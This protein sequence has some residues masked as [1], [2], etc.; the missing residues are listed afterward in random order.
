MSIPRNLS[1]L[2][3]NVDSNGTLSAAAGG[4][5]ATT[6]TGSG[7][8]VLSNSPTLVTPALGTPSS[9]TLT[10]ATG[11]PLSTGVTGNLPVTNLNS[12][13]SASSTTFWRGDG[14]WAIP[15]GGGGGSPAGSNGWVQF[16]NSGSFGAD[17]GFYWDNTNK[18]LSVNSG[19]SPTDSLQVTG[20][21]AIGTNYIL[22][23]NVSPTFYISTTGN[24][25]TGTGTNGNPWATLN[26]AM[27][28]IPQFMP[29]GRTNA[30]IVLKNGT[31]TLS[32]VQYIRGFTGGGGLYIQAETAGS[33]TV[34]TNG[35]QYEIERNDAQIFFSGITF[36][37]ATT[38]AMFNIR[39]T[40]QVTFSSNCAINQMVSGGNP[41]NFNAAFQVSNSGFTLACPL[42]VYNEASYGAVINIYSGSRYAIQGTISKSGGRHGN[43]AV[44]IQGTAEGQFQSTINNFAI[45]INMGRSHYDAEGFGLAVAN[46]LSVTNCNIGIQLSNNGSFKNY[47]I[48]ST[49]GTTTPVYWINGWFSGQFGSEYAYIGYSTSVSSSYRLQVNSQIYAT[50]STIATS[51]GRYKQNVATVANGLDI[52]KALRPVQFDWIPHDIHNFDTEHTTVG[53][54]A[55]E[56]RE[57]LAGTDY[58]DSIIKPHYITREAEEYETVIVTPAIEEIIDEDGNVVSLAAPPVTEKR[59]TKPAVTEE[60]LGIAE[61]NLI[62]ILTKAIQEQQVIIESLKARLDAA[63]L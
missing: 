36:Q 31:Y 11:L 56:V 25:T 48:A 9:A 3:D 41:G 12:G 8:V 22:S 23:D 39:D 44:S 17:G 60:F 28:A 58:V 57:A 7:S 19:T 34:N 55:Q 18:R 51:D 20:R 43:A 38:P 26:K 45:G 35:Y 1:K 24:D 61:G 42:T 29:N 62:A 27:V 14:T 21:I 6:S 59:I 52:V 15:A 40:L 16:N 54:I 53:F 50:S 2:A 49:S 46:G 33:V 5:G 47:Y 4:T 10:N 63:N 32:S 13:T 30:T 37:S